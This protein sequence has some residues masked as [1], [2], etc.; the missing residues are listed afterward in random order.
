MDDDYAMLGGFIGD[1]GWGKKGAWNAQK[2]DKAQ[3]R[4]RGMMQTPE[5]ILVMLVRIITN[6]MRTH[7]PRLFGR[8]VE[9]AFG[10][11]LGSIERK[12]DRNATCIVL[13][14][15]CLDL[16]DQSTGKPGTKDVIEEKYEN[17]W[18]TATVMA[19]NVS[20]TS[21]LAYAR[22]CSQLLKQ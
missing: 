2:L 15:A 10:D 9:E 8:E 18:K 6:E 3:K 19:K 1:I 13:G 11:M 14:L 5:Q 7:N 20:R 12:R 16:I 17:V 4:L 22:Y 21:L